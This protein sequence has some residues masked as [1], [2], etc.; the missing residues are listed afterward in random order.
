MLSLKV[1]T[2]LTDLRHDLLG[3][4]V[5]S[6]RYSSPFQRNQ[7][8]PPSWHKTLL[9][10]TTR[11]HSVQMPPIN[12][13]PH[14]YRKVTWLRTLPW[15]TWEVVT[16]VEEIPCWGLLRHTLATQ[17]KVEGTV[18]K[19]AWHWGG[20]TSVIKRSPWGTSPHPIVCRPSVCMGLCGQWPY[21]FPTFVGGLLTWGFR[22][23]CMNKSL[24]PE[25]E[26]P[27]P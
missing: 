18:L 23:N 13:T 6:H 25:T 12:P 1:Q 22:H 2:F 21:V 3:Y 8:H 19:A 11:L 4:T 26:Y 20:D 7:L 9:L 14:P 10:A 17:A 27:S 15:V 24:A 16:D 5:Y